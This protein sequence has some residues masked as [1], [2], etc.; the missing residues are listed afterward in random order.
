[1]EHITFA[2]AVRPVHK[3]LNIL[4]VADLYILP[5]RVL[6]CLRQAGI[7]NVYV[8]GNSRS[9]RLRYTRFSK[10]FFMSKINFDGSDIEG[11]LNEIN[12]YVK[13]L[14]ID[15][16]IAGD[17]HSTRLMT[18]IQPRVAAQ[19]FPLPDATSF[20]MLYNKWDFSKICHEHNVL[21]PESQ[22]LSSSKALMDNI[23]SNTITYPIICKP[24]NLEAGNGILKITEDNA[25]EQAARI[26]YQPV[27]VQQF[28]EGEDIGASVYCEKGV[29]KNFI[30]HYF[31][32]QTY[33]TFLNNRIYDAISKIL[34]SMKVSG[35]FNFDMR[36][37][38]EKEIYF[39]ECNPRFFEKMGMSALA[40]INF[41]AAGLGLPTRTHVPHGTKVRMP[42]VLAFT[43]FTKPHT[44]SRNDVMTTYKLAVDPVPFARE[45]FRVGWSDI[46][47]PINYYLDSK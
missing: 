45:L 26:Y 16:V 11:S 35:V 4:V 17:Q 40:G 37:S 27:L 23:R 14:A 38:L 19:C 28:I 3:K 41:V 10:R 39:I 9:A 1:M 15:I 34:G 22:L 29:I 18:L 33:H 8:L 47:T 20:N 32:R 12:R 2:Q 42:R 21:Y 30:A 24:H 13:K 7:S 25:L 36:L 5:Y 31:K 46:E 6:F 44:I 43:L